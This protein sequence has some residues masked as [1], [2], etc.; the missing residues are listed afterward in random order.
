MKNIVYL[1]PNFPT[2]FINF[3]AA[4]KKNGANVLGL[5]SEPF[6]HLNTKV[7]NCLNEYYKVDDLHNY[8]ELRKALGF[9]THKYGKIDGI[10]SH[11][12]YWLDTE[13][14][15]RDDFNI[16][17]LK[18]ADIKKARSKSGMKEVFREAGMR[19]AKG[20]IVHSFE[21]ATEFVREVGYPVVAKPDSGVGASDTFKIN[22]DTELHEVFNKI[23]DVN[24][25]ME[26]FITGQIHSFDGLAD[27]HSNPLFFTSHVFNDGIMEI[28]NN[29]KNL[30]YYSVR[31]VPKQLEEL[32]RKCLKAFGVKGRFFHIEFFYTPD[33]EYVPLEVNLRPPGGLSMDMFNY[34]CDINLYQTWGDMIVKDKCIL[35]YE[36]KYHV[37]YIGRKNGKNYVYEHKN[38]LEKY[39]DLIILHQEMPHVFRQAMGDYCYMAK[40]EDFDS[41]QEMA[42]CI[43]EEQ[44]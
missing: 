37:I 34:A 6:Q 42:N 33:G 21:G 12:E 7:K 15:L 9:F 16:P 44:N 18:T 31:K 8:E 5:G 4:L 30:Y 1:S 41:L 38:I 11:N 36:R 29:N 13:A 24:Y 43:L 28:V 23:P 35:N 27:Y 32:G 3:I 10:D 2:N 26:E 39:N 40:S 19:V 14:K 17:G 25:I 20:R 22:N